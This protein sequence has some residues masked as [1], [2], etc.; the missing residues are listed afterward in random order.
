[1]VSSHPANGGLISRTTAF[2][3]HKA[4][5]VERYFFGKG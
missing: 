1:M 5:A 3:L 4:C 2:E